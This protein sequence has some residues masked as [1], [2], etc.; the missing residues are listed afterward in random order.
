M[1]V[2]QGGGSFG[3]R[4]FFD[5]A[6][7]AARISKAMRPAGEADVDRTDDMR[8]GRV[9]AATP[10]Q[11][12]RHVRASGRC[13]AYEH[14]VALGGDRLPARPRRD[15]HRD[16]GRA[17]SRQP[18]LRADGVPHDREA[19]PYN[20]GVVTE[21]LNEPEPPLLHTARVALGLLRRR[22]RCRGDHGRRAGGE[23]AART[24]SR[25]GGRVAE[26]QRAARGAGQGRR[27]GRVGPGDAE[28]GTRRAS[29][30]TRSTSHARPAW[31]RSTPATRRTRG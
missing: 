2:V 14:R 27:A 5:G 22:P 29:A 12:P 28:P 17:A 31:S 1:H 9:R 18:R 24:R 16:G 30:S 23:A 11:G 7:E 6:L 25:S 26:G 21:L 15:P 3:R 8:H 4:L 10:P 13:S 19:C 20:F